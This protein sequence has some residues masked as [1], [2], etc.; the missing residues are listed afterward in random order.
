MKNKEICLIERE[1]YGNNQWGVLNECYKR[2]QGYCG[3]DYILSYVICSKSGYIL[4]S[5]LKH[6][7]KSTLKQG[8]RWNEI[9]EQMVY[10]SAKVL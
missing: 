6:V 3:I 7:M 4:K 9:K 5:V 2:F 10:L 1:K 8:N